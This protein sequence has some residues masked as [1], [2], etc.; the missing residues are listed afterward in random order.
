[1]KTLRIVARAKQRS[2]EERLS[3]R[4][5]SRQVVDARLRARHGAENVIAA[6]PVANW[7]SSVLS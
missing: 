2:F 1:M 6:A 7:Y 5:R 4:L 3:Q